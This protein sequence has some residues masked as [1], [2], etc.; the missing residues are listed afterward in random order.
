MKL[1][2][3]LFFSYFY[4]HLMAS[5]IFLVIFV[6]SLPHRA[7][8][9][10][11]SNWWASKACKSY[12]QKPKNL[13]KRS[14]VA[15][16]VTSGMNTVNGALVYRGIPSDLRFRPGQSNHLPGALLPRW[17]HASYWVFNGRL[18]IQ[19]YGKGAYFHYNPICDYN[20]KLR[21]KKFDLWWNL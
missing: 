18:H 15:T 21:Q 4:L 7:A 17:L 3:L 6:E 16:T 11:L 2:K 10:E 19:L 9:I 14:P 13:T 1:M 5:N 8:M 12:Q 20:F